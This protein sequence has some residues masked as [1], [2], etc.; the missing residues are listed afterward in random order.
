M[1]LFFIYVELAKFKVRLEISILLLYFQI[2]SIFSILAGPVSSN[3][4]GLH[5]VGLPHRS[6]VIIKEFTGDLFKPKILL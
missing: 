3:H 1:L 6:N 4:F 5:L 2:A